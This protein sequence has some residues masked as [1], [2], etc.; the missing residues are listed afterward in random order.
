MRA[1]GE[2]CKLFSSP[3]PIVFE[4]SELEFEFEAFFPFQASEL[5]KSGISSSNN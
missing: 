2:E 3:S 1:G 5:I 4:I